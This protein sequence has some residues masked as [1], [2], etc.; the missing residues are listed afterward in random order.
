MQ[1]GDVVQIDP[2]VGP[3]IGGCFMTVEKLTENEYVRGYVLVPI[4]GR[5]NPALARCSFPIER[6]K[7]IGR[8]EWDMTAKA[9]QRTE[10]GRYTPG[11]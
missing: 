2:K 11:A 9:A 7:F 1:P 4:N 3:P 10:V 5:T 8:L 6:V